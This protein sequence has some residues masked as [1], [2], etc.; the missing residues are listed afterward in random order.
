MAFA[1]FLYI[2]LSPK[3]K[4]RE[5]L[6]RCERNPNYTA[7]VSFCDDHISHIYMEMILKIKCSPD[8]QICAPK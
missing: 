6:E 8:L 5:Y 4:L 7:A 2:K 3:E 1:H